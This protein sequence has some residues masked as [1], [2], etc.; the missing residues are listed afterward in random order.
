MRTPSYSYDVAVY[1]AAQRIILRSGCGAATVRAVAAESG[2]S[3]STVRY[4]FRDQ[5]HL[6]AC[7]FTAV[8]DHFSHRDMWRAAPLHRV[9][10]L[11]V[12]EAVQ[13]MMA[14]LPADGESLEQLRLLHAYRAWA[15]HDWTMAISMS[16][17]DRRL[18]N[19][20]QVVLQ[21]LGLPPAHVRRQAR[22]LR[23]VIGGLAEEIVTL[24]EPPEG[25]RRLALADRITDRGVRAFL[26]EHLDAVLAR[27]VA[28]HVCAPTADEPPVDR[29]G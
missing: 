16:G 2:V 13:I 18:L 19:L 29:A 26:T 3:P 17:F 6:L 28:P 10:V 27:A 7:A 21:R 20:C 14:R 25:E 22:I 1:D 24:C 5:S 9:E 15:R 8:D 23:V 11:E 4:H 12:S